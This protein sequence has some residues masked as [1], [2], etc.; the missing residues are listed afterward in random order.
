MTNIE[1]LIERYGIEVIKRIPEKYSN[2]NYNII[3]GVQI[4][5]YGLIEHLKMSEYIASYKHL[6]GCEYVG[7][8]FNSLEGAKIWVFTQ[9][10]LEGFYIR[11]TPV[12]FVTDKD[13]LVTYKEYMQLYYPEYIH[14]WKHQL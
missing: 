5:M 8:W 6:I 11:H 9:D 4:S 14:I 12:L 13:E 10:K 7:S 3:Y 1:K 2:I